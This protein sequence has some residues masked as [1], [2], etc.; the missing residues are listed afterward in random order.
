[1][2]AP[3]TKTRKSNPSAPRPG[4]NMQFRLD[5]YDGIYSSE[6]L[7]ILKQRGRKL[8]ELSIGIAKP[9]NYIQ[10][11]FLSVINGEAEAM[12][13]AETAWIKYIQRKEIIRDYQEKEKYFR[14]AFRTMKASDEQLSWIG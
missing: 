11:H 2:M 6:E 8:F 10:W 14:Q 9:K 4:K 3:I 13:V 12:T 5:G 1:M 7:Q